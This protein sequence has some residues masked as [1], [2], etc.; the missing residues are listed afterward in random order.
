MCPLLTLSGPT[1]TQP[2]I[3]LEGIE[4]PFSPTPILSYVFEVRYPVHLISSYDSYS[5]DQ[6]QRPGGGFQFCKVV[7]R[8]HGW[9]GPI[10][11]DD[12]DT[13]TG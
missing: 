6:I 1:C 11:A 10:C 9:R 7:C 12:L 2:M 5:T 4:A 3:E 8:S 13:L